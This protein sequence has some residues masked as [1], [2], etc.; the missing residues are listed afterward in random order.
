MSVDMETIKIMIN[1]ATFS[2]SQKYEYVFILLFAF[3]NKSNI[4]SL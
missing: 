2:M 3:Y 4:K 1:V